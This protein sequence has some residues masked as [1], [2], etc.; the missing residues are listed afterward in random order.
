MSDCAAAATVAAV[1]PNQKQG[2]ATDNEDIITGTKLNN[3]QGDNDSLP[4]QK[5]SQ[6]WMSSISDRLKKVWDFGGEDSSNSVSLGTENNVG[7]TN[8][9]ATRGRA[10]SGAGVS[11]SEE[12][13]RGASVKA[14]CKMGNGGGGGVD[15]RETALELERLLGAVSSYEGKLEGFLD[16]QKNMVGMQQQQVAETGAMGENAGEDHE[17]GSTGGWR[18]TL[19]CFFFVPPR[20]GAWQ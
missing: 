6:P 9:K 17:D 19:V 12:G 5:Q 14:A 8:N 2:R 4:K 16:M 13:G 10:K 3:R 7:V 20:S 18:M 15:D 1:A 11:N